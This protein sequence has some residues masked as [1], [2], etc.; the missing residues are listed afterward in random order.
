MEKVQITVTVV[1]VVVAS[2]VVNYLRNIKVCVD[3]HAFLL[4]LTQLPQKIGYIPGMR[5]LFS[6]VSPFGASIPTCR[7]NPG[8][9][10]QWLWRKTGEQSTKSTQEHRLTF[11]QPMLMQ[12]R[13][14]SR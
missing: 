10:W 9:N 1:A 12:G 14:P 13:I 8:I 5:C 6:P 7:F 4:T 2:V 3:M 11:L